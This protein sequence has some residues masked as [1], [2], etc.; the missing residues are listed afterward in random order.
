MN[1]MIPP[2]EEMPAGVGM[3]SP[4]APE[5]QVLPSAMPQPGIDP[6]QPV[7][8]EQKKQLLAMIDAI[9]QKLGSFQ[10]NHFANNNALDKTR[11]RLLQQMFEKMQLAGIDLTNPES[12]SAFIEKLRQQSPE[13]AQ[14]FEEAIDAL[15]GDDMT[16]GSPANPGQGMD[17]GTSTPPMMQ[18]PVNNET[19]NPQDNANIPEEVR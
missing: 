5:S 9:R 17:L 4:A 6:A 12:V 1:T 3:P 15:L 13:L 19:I 11:R 7:S 8:E 14:Q 16:A 18:P 10:A 2:Q